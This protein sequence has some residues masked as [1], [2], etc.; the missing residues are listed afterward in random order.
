[1]H[2]QGGGLV[3]DASCGWESSRIWRSPSRRCW[4]PERIIA[5][6][7]PP[8]SPLL[9]PRFAAWLLILL[10][11]FYMPG[12]MD[13]DTYRV[14]GAVVG[15]AP[16]SPASCSSLTQAARIPYVRHFRLRLPRAGDDSADIAL[17]T[18]AG[19]GL[20]AD[21]RSRALTVTGF[22]FAA[23]SPLAPARCP[24]LVG[25]RRRRLT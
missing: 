20:A 7:L 6:A 24:L 16:G 8:A 9:W 3:R 15:L 11:L 25:G 13:L 5:M 4:R 10:S 18:C 21:E 12:A 2:A 22:V 14:D 17:Q 19:S 23:S 1:M